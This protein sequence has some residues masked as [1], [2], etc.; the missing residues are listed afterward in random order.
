MSKTLDVAIRDFKATVLTKAFI[1]GV[2]VVPAL[3]AGSMPLA[4]ILVSRKSPEIRGTIAVIDRSGGDGLVTP[5]IQKFFAPDALARQQESMARDTSEAM[6]QLAD[7]AGATPD[8]AALARS[9][10][11]TAAQMASLPTITPEILKPDADNAAIEA[12]KQPL[13]GGSGDNAEKG[14]RLAL[15]VIDPD[16]VTSRDGRSFGSYQLYVRPKLDSRAQEA[17]RAQLR[18]AVIQARLTANGQDPARILA[19][20]TL[21]PPPPIAVTRAGEKSSNEMQQV[22]TPFAFMM[23]LWISVF[24][25]GQF[26]MTSTIEEKSSRV[27]EVLLSAVSPMQLMT[28]K[29]LGQMGAGLLILLT[30]T[31]VGIATLFY[32]NRSDLL[33]WVNVGFL[34][35]FFLIAFFTI[36]SMMAAIGSAVSDM[37]EAQALMMPVMS[38]VMIPMLLMMPIIYNPNGKLATIMGFMPPISPFVMVLRM[39]SSDPPPMWQ[40]LVATLIGAGTVYVALRITAKIF[41]IGVLMYGKPPNFATLMRWVRQA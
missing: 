37:H 23:L 12:A 2:L 14:G 5:L 24:A 16:A 7:K 4:M 40:P 17:L 26:L 25:A 20:T 18:K 10:A 34:L 41:R 31:G 9:T 3:V 33:E 28:G 39:S 35:V 38:I 32:F 30:Y 21:Q 13:L 29:I 15:V 8:Q 11:A 19:M 22:F 6:G 1:I 27:M 36:A